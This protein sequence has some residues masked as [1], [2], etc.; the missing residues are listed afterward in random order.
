MRKLDKYIN[1]LNSKE[2]LTGV[3]KMIQR[4]DELDT[5]I[6]ILD[7]PGEVK[8]IITREELDA[9]VNWKSLVNFVGKE[10]YFKVLSVDEQNGIVY[11]SR[12]AAQQEIKAEIV[13][14]LKNGEVFDA[15]IINILRYG[16][17]V[18]I[19]GIT[20][21]LKNVDFSVDHTTV[22]DVFKVGDKVKVKLKKISANGRIVFEANEK[23]QSPTIMNFDIFKR[24]QVVLGTIR[25]IKPFG[26]Y[27]CIAPNLDAL[28]PLPPF[29]NIEEG[30]KVSMRITRVMPEE[31]R[32]RGKILKVL[33]Q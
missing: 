17:Y 22:G 20:G 14:R 8:G 16:A 4:D 2:T 29:G 11:C 32:I 26:V 18:D 19:N 15:E 30:M 27:V 9:D 25:N 33:P 23:Y 24:D 31:R 1:A 13:E 28:C 3:V 7:L 10:V 6:L 12:K 21:L 5:D